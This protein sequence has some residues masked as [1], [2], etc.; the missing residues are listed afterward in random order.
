[1]GF[2]GPR[3]LTVADIRVSRRSVC[4][5]LKYGSQREMRPS[6]RSVCVP[7]EL[8]E[9]VRLRLGDSG[10]VLRSGQNPEMSNDDT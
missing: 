6:R 4:V 2:D 5:M 7:L 8:E 1:M 9:G 10:A 3:T